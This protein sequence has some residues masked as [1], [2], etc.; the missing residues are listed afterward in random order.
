MKRNK[1][2]GLLNSHVFKTSILLVLIF[3]IVG[4]LGVLA[5]RDERN[6]QVLGTSTVAE[7]DPSFNYPITAQ[8]SI[9]IT[10]M[11]RQQTD[12]KL[13]LG[14]WAITGAGNR[15]L[16]RVNT[17]GTK[18]TSFDVGVGPD[19][20]DI[21]Q[22]QELPNGQI[23]VA[24]T[25]NTWNDSFDYRSVIRLN[26]DGSQDMSFRA[27]PTAGSISFVV[28]PDEKIIIGGFYAFS[29]RPP[30]GPLP[31]AISRFN[32]D[33]SVDSSFNVGTGFRGPYLD[34]VYTLALQ[35]D[36]SVIAGGLLY[37]FNGTR[38]HGIVRLSSTGALDTTFNQGGSGFP[39][40]S[41]IEKVIVQPDGKILVSGRFSSYNGITRLGILRL[42]NDGT[43]DTSFNPINTITHPYYIR[44]SNCYLSSMALLPNGMIIIIGPFDSI[45]G[46]TEN[47][48]ARINAN[49]TLDTTFNACQEGFTEG[50]YTD[51]MA[52][53]DA[54]GSSANV[55][56]LSDDDSIYVG[57]DFYTYHSL[58]R[59][60]VV[61][62]NNIGGGNASSC[63]T[64][65]P[66][67]TPTPTPTLACV[68]YG[69]YTPSGICGTSRLCPMNR[70]CALNSLVDVDPSAVKCIN[71]SYQADQI[72]DC[73]P[74]GML[75]YMGAC[76][77]EIPTNTPTP[78]PTN[79]PT[80]TPTS[81]PTQTTTP[82]PTV[83]I[84]S[85]P[86]TTVTI[87]PTA[88]TTHTATPT[89]THTPTIATTQ[90][91]T[92]S[93]T[94][95][96]TP[97]P[98]VSTSFT[99]TV[100]NT[101]SAMPTRTP[102]PTIETTITNIPKVSPSTLGVTSNGCDARFTTLTISNTV[103]KPGDEVKIT[104]NTKNATLVTYE[105]KKKQ[106]PVQG[107]FVTRLN[108]TTTITMVADNGIC[109]TKKALNVYVAEVSPWVTNTFIGG[110]VAVVDAAMVP[111]AIS[112]AGALQEGTAV[113]QVSM[114]G[115]IWY[116]LISFIERKRK[117]STGVVYSATTKKPLAR[118]ILHLIDA[119]TQKVVD[120]SV[121]DATG[122][123]RFA[124][125]KG[126]YVIE[127]LLKEY[128][129]PSKLIKTI[130]DG[131][132][133][134]VYTGGTIEIREDNAQLEIAIPM[135]A[136]DISQLTAQITT[137]KPLIASI[138]EITSIGLFIVGFAYSTY[139]TFL[140]PHFY[141]Y[142]VLS[143]YLLYIGT[144]GFIATR[145]HKSQGRVLDKQGKPIPGLEIGLF[146]YEFNNNL[147]RTFT[148][149]DGEYNFVVG[150]G[151][152]LLQ[153]MDD[154]YQIE[155]KGTRISGLHITVN[156]KRD[157]PYFIVEDIHVVSK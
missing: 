110:T 115:N 154:R 21:S 31:Y 66:T 101:L 85:T 126:T 108:E 140:Y 78:S 45:N 51:Y 9:F 13:L 103:V 39:D 42:N 57:G 87:S 88:T 1:K 71:H 122:V 117:R 137:T 15:E 151:E 70:N 91:I 106:L 62:L 23:Y 82:S 90:T 67:A 131:G 99:P 36:G 130:N 35:P 111:L 25:Y 48:I 142:V 34:I 125:K 113:A 6:G 104:W 32:T 26:S 96:T 30:A 133:A 50:R 112:L 65:T 156:E 124:A 64:P 141:N 56:A 29:S 5:T 43:L 3:S 38:V 68:D 47:R 54:F 128:T 55:I 144:R 95:T 157:L 33:G 138:F 53:S 49:G 59:Q 58:N 63:S 46:N 14:G 116:A 152:Y 77:T 10:A 69:T 24:G 135:D 153:L 102:M 86:T 136:I 93:V 75:I 81:T 84:T 72:V 145:K 129:F 114:N 120:T 150:K 2:T 100:S 143:G 97:S 61:K 4:F 127:A 44:C 109:I 12:G 79:T 146:D 134:H 52:G 123:F 28:Q 107:S 7:L 17:D 60:Y 40:G 22:I 27:G 92:P 83:T 76:V 20:N 98:T 89:V 19:G 155:E 149:K 94:D 73:C 132:Y 37:E 41:T 16:I 105:E 139:I 18:D 74:F 8:E 11:S 121:T 147:Y 118:V 119:E 148:S 80:S